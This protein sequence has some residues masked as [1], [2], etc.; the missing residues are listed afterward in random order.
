MWRID[1]DAAHRAIGAGLDADDLVAVPVE[2]REFWPR[3]A[4]D[5]DGDAE[6]EHAELVVGED[7]DVAVLS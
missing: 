5:F 3:Q 6:L 1:G 2:M 7:G 4:E